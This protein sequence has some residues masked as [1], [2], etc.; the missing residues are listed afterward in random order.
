MIATLLV[1]VVLML[2]FIFFWYQNFFHSDSAVKVLLANEIF[3]TGQ[4]FPRNWNYANG[5]LFILFG[6]VF[7]IPFLQFMPAGYTVHAISGAIVAALMLW[8]VWLITSFGSV[9]LWQRLVI[10]SVMASGVSGFIAENLYGQVSYGSIFL[11]S[12]YLVYFSHRYLIADKVNEKTFWSILIIILLS[13][14]Y[15][16]NPK[17]AA[18]SYGFPLIM[19]LFWM[20]LHV[21][22]RDSLIF[23][24][25][26]AISLLGALIGS[27]SHFLTLKEVNNH[28]GAAS[29]RWLSFDDALINIGLVI[30]GF[31]AQLSGLLPANVSIFTFVGGY[32]G[33]RFI[34]ACTALYMIPIAFKNSMTN[35]D[36]GLRLFGLFSFF[37]L[38]L[39]LFMQ[40]TTTI[41]NSSESVSSTRYLVPVLLMIIIL[42]LIIPFKRGS[43]P[44]VPS[45]FAG[46]IAL[47][48]ITGGYHAYAL[49]DPSSTHVGKF[50]KID[51]ERRDL[52]D[53]IKNNG[54]QYGYASY[55]HANSLTVLSDN[56]LKI[57]PINF[58]NGGVM[59]MRWLSSNDWYRPKAWNGKTFLLLDPSEITKINEQKL[60]DLGL[61]PFEKLKFRD[62]TILVF[63]DNLSLKIRGW[64]SSYLKPAV[65]LPAVDTLTQAGQLVEKDCK[66]VLVPI[67]GKIGALHFGPYIYLEPG[68]YRVT[69]D[70]AAVH[71]EPGSLR[72]DVASSPDQKIYGELTLTES[73][74]PQIIEFTLDKMR[75]M[76]FRVFA[77]NGDQVTFSGITIQRI[78]E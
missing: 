46:L 55:W 25:L 65:F 9:P 34:A 8:G 18:V 51:A 36:Q 40:V 45:L 68:R 13:L 12:I 17:R 24:K 44:I 60:V 26:I 63:E 32:A 37:L 7:I 66:K 59:P 76:E 57:R 69:F 27:F 75:T 4:F 38:G 2:G 20:S 74:K 19:S 50:K 15:W 72:L 31:Y 28:L 6:H 42:I 11:V 21:R 5:D 48:L 78:K 54:L 62:F 29:A 47:T 39:T 56:I 14:A 35:A 41:P 16:S 70:V 1:N 43:S 67:R 22:G 58:T 71:N 23:K 3:E 49:S 64:D 30:K 61:A 33:M 77:L 52:I 53:Y 10:V 73:D